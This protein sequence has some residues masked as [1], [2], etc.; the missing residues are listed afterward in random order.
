MS[1]LNKLSMYPAE[2]LTEYQKPSTFSAFQQLEEPYTEMYVEKN[3]SKPLYK[4]VISLYIKSTI[5]TMVSFKHEDENHVTVGEQIEEFYSSEFDYS[6]KLISK[7]TFK[8]KVRV[9]SISR[10]LPSP[11]ID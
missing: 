11:F 5:A 9:K 1:L 7:K 3:W 2:L 10:F 8:V 6:L 4:D